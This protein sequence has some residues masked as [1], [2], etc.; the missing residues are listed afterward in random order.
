MHCSH[1]SLHIV[2]GTAGGVCVG[3]I[4]FIIHLLNGVVHLIFHLSTSN[5]INFICARIVTFILNS[6]KVHSHSPFSIVIV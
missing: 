5:N 4:V 1:L 2:D 3:A 6:N